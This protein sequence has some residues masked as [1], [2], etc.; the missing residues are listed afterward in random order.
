MKNKVIHIA[1]RGLVPDSVVRAGI[2]HLLKG[3]LQ[4]EAQGGKFRKEQ[5]LEQLESSPVAVNTKEANEQHYELPTAFFKNM[6]G[7]RMK[8]SCC[9]WESDGATL[10]EAEEASLSLVAERAGI[11][12]GQR[13]LDLG[14]GW[15]S[16]A[17]WAAERFPDSHFLA[18]SN[19]QTQREWI[20]ACAHD[21]QLHNLEVQTADINEFSPSQ[22]VDRIVSIEMLEH[23][24]N[25]ETIFRRASEWLVPD[26]R[27][28]IHVFTHREYTYLFE[29]GDGVDWMAE[30]FFTG[31]IMPARD[32]F[33]RYQDHMAIEQEW[34]LNGV[35]YQRTLEAW[36]Q[37]YDAKRELILESLKKCYGDDHA[38]FWLHRWRLFLMACSELFGYCNGHEW[39]VTHYLLAPLKNA[40]L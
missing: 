15:G 7:P 18:V 35:H 26:G 5:T 9:Y 8:Y 31:G 25:H 20:Q 10:H 32:L 16:F 17:L 39:Y 6:L 23:V 4:Q 22:P 29:T 28:F 34:A 27:F 11:R 13:V 33:Y 21:L 2:R 40:N 24:R 12:N 36:L 19:S 30:N 1:E 38:R 14:C 3:R 37:Q